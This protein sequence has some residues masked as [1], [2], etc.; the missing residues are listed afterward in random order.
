MAPLDCPYC[1]HKEEM[2]D[3]QTKAL[4]NALFKYEI[5]DSVSTPMAEIIKGNIAIH[6]ICPNCKEF[7]EAKIW[8][9]DLK[10]INMATYKR[11]SNGSSQK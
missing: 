11:E 1:Q 4:E 9:E 7:V 6:A 10:L 3:W 5:G 2:H 8:I